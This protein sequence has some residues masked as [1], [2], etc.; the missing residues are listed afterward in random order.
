MQKLPHQMDALRAGGRKPV[1]MIGAGLSYGIVPLVDALYEK[2]AELERRLFGPG[3]DPVVGVTD[4]YDWADA[5]LARLRAN[6]E[7]HAKYRLACA[8]GLLDE[9]WRRSSDEMALAHR[10]ARHRVIA[11]LARERRWAAIWSLNW[12]CVLE[13]TLEQVGFQLEAPSEPLPWVQ[14]YGVTLL[15]AHIPRHA[16]SEILEIVKPHGCARALPTHDP[17]TSEE[18]ALCERLKIGRRELD[19]PDARANDADRVFLHRF[20]VDLATSPFVMVGWS[21]SEPYLRRLADEALGSSSRPVGELSIVDPSFQEG[22]A[23]LA[24]HYGQSREQCHFAVAT[25]SAGLT[26]DRL[27]LHIQALFGLERLAAAAPWRLRRPLAEARSLLEGFAAPG[28]LLDWFDCFLPAWT[29]LCW[30]AGFPD[31]DVDF[32]PTSIRTD[33]PDYHVP[34]G[35]DSVPDRPDLAMAAFLLAEILGAGERWS[36]SR[37]PGAWWSEREALRVLPLPAS[38]QI[39][40]SLALRPLL[41]SF[42]ADGGLAA[43][44]EILPVHPKDPRV[45]TNQ[46]LARN[47]SHKIRTLAPFLP[48]PDGSELFPV[49]VTPRNGR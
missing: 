5:V 16:G 1:L 7:P 9:R 13:A 11:R 42:A 31:R 19:D 35:L 46:G 3:A 8:L 43:R 49:R 47:L 23:T 22:H 32:D 30:R 6:G 20:C 12:D 25:G 4:L 28:D 2:R 41:D 40:E 48:L 34:W 45:V 26:T 36:F 21:V 39:S 14:R 29:R 38:H 17:R 37:F 15:E 10:S 33:R 27:F 44:A 24:A 18:A